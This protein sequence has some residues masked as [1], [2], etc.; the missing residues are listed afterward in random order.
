MRLLLLLTLGVFLHAQPPADFDQRKAQARAAIEA[1]KAQTAL[2]L[3][4]PLVVKAPDDYELGLTLAKAYRLLG[5]LAEAEKQTQWLLDLRPEFLGGLWE[6][7]LL[8]EAFQ[9]L[10]GATD[11]LSQ[12]YRATP[13][14]KRSTRIAVLEDLARVFRKQQLAADAALIKTEI[15]RLKELEKQDAPSATFLYRNSTGGSR[16]LSDAENL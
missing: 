4:S 6:A 7:A 12:V 5:K 16:P 2:D 14:S 15:L 10:V 8:R 11:L 9:D 1:G 13:A 3:A